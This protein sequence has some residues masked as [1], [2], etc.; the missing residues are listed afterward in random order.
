M[1]ENTTLLSPMQEYLVS[2]CKQ[3]LPEPQSSLLASILIGDKQSLDPDFK[4]ALTNTSTI[5]MVVVSGQNLSM[6][7]GFLLTLAPW[8]GRKKTILSTIAI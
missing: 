5:H 8:I 2:L 3:V 6:L 1:E 4:K 7:A